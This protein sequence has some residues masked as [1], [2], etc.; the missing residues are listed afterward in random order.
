MKKR[1]NRYASLEYAEYLRVRKSGVPA[2]WKKGKR[3][4]DVRNIHFQT[5]KKFLGLPAN[6]EESA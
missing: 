2:L 1:P 5:G 6:V 3:S 4:F